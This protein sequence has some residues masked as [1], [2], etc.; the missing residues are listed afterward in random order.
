MLTTPCILQLSAIRIVFTGVT[1]KLTDSLHL[2][3]VMFSPYVAPCA[4]GGPLRA[5]GVH[6]CI[7]CLKDG[8]ECVRDYVIYPKIAVLECYGEPFFALWVSCVN[9]MSFTVT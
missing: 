1:G 4:L 8:L 5:V 3:Q 9:T 2:L 6:V 7:A